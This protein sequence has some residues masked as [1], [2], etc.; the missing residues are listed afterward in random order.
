MTSPEAE[1]SC[2]LHAG[3]LP[4]LVS[5][6]HTGTAIPAQLA[7]RLTPQALA[8]PDTDWYLER[9]YDFVPARGASL[10]V[11]RLSR[12]VVDLNRPPQD[13]QMYPGQNNT[14]LCPRRDFHGQPL[15]RDGQEPD[16][17]E[18]DRR[19]A[20]WWVPYH[21]AIAQELA[22]LRAR[23]GY[24]VLLDGHSICS[25]LP[26]LFE[27]R[28]PD[29]NLGTVS[30]S[31]CAPALRARLTRLL[32]GQTRFSQVVDGRFR[33]GYITRHY[34]QPAQGVHAVQLE[35]CWSTYMPECAPWRIDPQRAAQLGDFLRRLVDSLLQAPPEA[36]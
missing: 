13:E 15:Y 31:S 22:R 23:H 8:V 6:P 16:A 19:R 17:A 3:E 2:R 25:Q 11:P 5:L 1:P 26:W 12:Y 14:G 9:L 32:A 35:M 36:P 7:R 20:D 33:G 24:A 21:T 34:G 28:L 10:I 4:L 27:G 29:L 18:V 30:G